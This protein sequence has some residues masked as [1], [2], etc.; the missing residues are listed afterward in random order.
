MSCD[1]PS[2]ERVFAAFEHRK[3]DR[4]PNFEILIEDRHTSRLLK[5]TVGHTLGSAKG[6]SEDEYVTPPMDPADYVEICR[7]I[8]QDAIGIVN[9]A[10]G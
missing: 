5:R 6:A 2:I 1:Q 4:V 7:L 10:A 8:G 3:T 9:V